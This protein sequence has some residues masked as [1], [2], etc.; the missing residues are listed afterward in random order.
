IT[1]GTPANSGSPGGG[2]SIAGGSSPTI[3]R[4]VVQGNRSNIWAG[5][6][7]VFGSVAHIRD[8]VIKDNVGSDGGGITLV[9]SSGEILNNGISG[10]SAARGG[11][12]ELSNSSATVENDRISSN[13]AYNSGG[14]L[15]LEGASAATVV[16]DL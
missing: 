11:G 1:G 3:S 6:I 12:I 9:N 2:I 14:G 4:N 10:N 15:V 8:N 13:V 5:G 16:Q 7:I